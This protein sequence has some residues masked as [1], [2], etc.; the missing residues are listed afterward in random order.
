MKKST[1][2]HRA[3]GNYLANDL[4][5]SREM[6]INHMNQ[7]IDRKIDAILQDKVDQ[8]FSSDWLQNRIMHRVGEVL[9]GKVANCSPFIWDESSGDVDY[10]KNRLDAVIQKEVVKR[11]K[12]HQIDVNLK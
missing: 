2:E 7:Y 10:L 3:I 4:G 5:I 9:Q 6:V 11:I 12:F 1:V 8:L